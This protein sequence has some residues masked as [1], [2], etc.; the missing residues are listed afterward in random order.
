MSRI[1]V[2][3]FSSGS[4]QSLKIVPFLPTEASNNNDKSS[5]MQNCKNCE[6]D[7]SKLQYTGKRHLPIIFYLFYTPTIAIM[8]QLSLIL[9]VKINAFSNLQTWFVAISVSNPNQIVEAYL[10]DVAD[11]FNLEVSFAIYFQM[12]D[13][14]FREIF[15]GK[16]V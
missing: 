15:I 14:L 1:L 8:W 5:K 11:K 2:I 9:K 3:G 16:T 13:I 4:F 12:S 6:I 10:C 7:L